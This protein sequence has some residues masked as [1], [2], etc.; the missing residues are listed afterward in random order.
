VKRLLAGETVTQAE[1][2]LG[3]R[4]WSELM[5]TLGREG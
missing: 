3:K 5:A 1:S 4:E 2:A